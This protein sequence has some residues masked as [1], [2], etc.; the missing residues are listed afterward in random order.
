MSIGVVAPFLTQPSV[1][2]RLRGVARRVAD[3]EYRLR[4]AGRR[5][6][7]PPLRL[8]RRVRGQRPRRR[9]A[10]RLPRAARGLPPRQRADRPRGPPERPTARAST[11]TTRPAAGSP[12]EHLIELG[13]TRI[14]FV[15]DVEENPYGFD[16]SA[17]RR[18]RLRG[19]APRRRRDARPDARADGAPRPRRRARDGARAARSAAPPTAIFAACDDAGA[20][21][22][23]S[24]RGGERFRARSSLR[25]RASTT[26]RWRAT[27][28]SPPSRSRS[29]R[30]APAAWICSWTRWRAERR[31]RSSWTASSSFAPPRRRRSSEKANERGGKPRVRTPLLNGMMRT[32]RNTGGGSR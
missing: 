21:R 10:R 3:A 5:A 23:R 32:S 25:G 12:T 24:G 29:S 2:E 6:P 18:A 16:S 31:A 13:H 11:S 20:R 27:R 22:A 15:G 1:V 30:A 28:T 26:S 17:H 19:G 7:R 9:P 14:G 8:G 4:A